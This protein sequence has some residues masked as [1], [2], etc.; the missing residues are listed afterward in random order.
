[1]G[2]ST[3]NPFSRIIPVNC[4]LSILSTHFVKSLFNFIL[5]KLQDQRNHSSTLELNFFFVLN[6]LFLKP[7]PLKFQLKMMSNDLSMHTRSRKQPFQLLTTAPEK[8]NS[9]VFAKHESIAVPLITPAS[10]SKISNQ[11]NSLLL[12]SNESPQKNLNPEAIKQIVLRM[13]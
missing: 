6:L 7:N 5:N 10:I 12:L 3:F 1:M 8:P 11:L 2:L 4:Q 13:F 9:D